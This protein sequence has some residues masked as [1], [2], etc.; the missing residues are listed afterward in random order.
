[1]KKRYL[2]LAC[3]VTF[4]LTGCVNNSGNS[5]N[6]DAKLFN[7]ISPEDEQC[8]VMDKVKEYSDLRNAAKE[9]NMDKESNIYSLGEYSDSSAIAVKNYMGNYDDSVPVELSFEVDESIAEETFTIRYWLENHEDE[10]IEVPALNGKVSLQNL[11]R[12]SNYEWQ[13]ISS[14]GKMSAVDYFSTADYIRIL[15]VKG[16]GDVQN[17]RDCGGW[18]T[19]DGKRFK[20]GLI[21]RGAEWNDHRLSNGHAQNIFGDD[22]P[23]K[24][25]LIDD[26]GIRCEIDL[27]SASEADISD[28]KAP[29]NY[30]YASEGDDNWV[31]YHR[32]PT[33]SY[34]RD[35][36][37][38]ASYKTIFEDYFANADEKPCYFH[39][40]GGADRT[41][42][43]AFLLGALLGMS[44]TDLIIDYEATSFYGSL[45]EHNHNSD[46]YTLFT[47]LLRTV[48]GWSFYSPEKT[49]QEVVETYLTE[50]CGVSTSAIEKIKDILLED[51]D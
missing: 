24:K 41:G 19:L 50:T 38:E 20:Q 2:K 18:T 27:R 28:M 33:T 34:L 21:Y 30:T 39:C 29:V 3:L 35:T 44:Y 17:V 14:S 6:K 22:D 1:M 16:Q 37:D 32:L 12:S 9:E 8:L 23:A 42:T 47:T 45:K 51:I 36:K 26:L 48:Q 11:Y 15:S 10:Y 7:L 31:E 43:I 5:E 46:Q 40:Y 49:L 4:L 13:V 25:I